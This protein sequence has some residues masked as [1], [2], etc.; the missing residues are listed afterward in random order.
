[1]SISFKKDES[2]NAT[3]CTV[4]SLIHAVF[5]MHNLDLILIRY[6]QKQVQNSTP[7][8]EIIVD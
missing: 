5:K 7:L 1:M 3:I 8:L 6:S 4:P 2:Q